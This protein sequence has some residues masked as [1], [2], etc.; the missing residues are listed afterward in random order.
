M[1]IG[2]II[3]AVALA[4]LIYTGRVTLPFFEP[5]AAA[6]LKSNLNRQ[7]EGTGDARRADSVKCSS[8]H[9]LDHLK[10]APIPNGVRFKGAYSC[11]VTWSDGTTAQYC[12]LDFSKNPQLGLLTSSCESAAR[13]GWGQGPFPVG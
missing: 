9:A 6:S 7:L 13:S 10:E 8:S 4:F 1:R 3:G 11:D 12:Q 2:I 5:S